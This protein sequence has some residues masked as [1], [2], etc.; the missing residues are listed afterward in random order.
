MFLVGNHESG[1][2]SLQYSSTKILESPERKFS[3]INTPCEWSKDNLQLLFLPYV[4]ESDRKP[5]NEYFTKKP[6][7]YTIL[8]SHNDL[9]NVQMGPV[10]SRVGFEIPELESIADITFNGHLHNGQKIT[11]KVINLGNATGRD[12]S[13]NANIYKHQIAILDTE[14]RQVEY[15]ENPYAFNFYKLDI[16]SKADLKFLNNLKQNAVLSVH[17]D[18]S[19]YSEIKEKIEARGSQIIEY[20]LTAT[21]NNQAKDTEKQISIADL[22]VD[23]HE[24]F[25]ECCREK[26]GLSDILEAELAEV[27]K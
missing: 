16:F 12:F 22:A 8:F 5:I 10:I 14:A 25:A 6:N 11:N 4:L 18:K 3:V 20:R 26:I 21:Q 7:A 17:C 19:L 1:Q 23:H 2:S 27:L 13:E 9:K 15:I 24:K